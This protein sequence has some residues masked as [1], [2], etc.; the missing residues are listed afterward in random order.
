M[1]SPAPA[2]VAGAKPIPSAVK[3]ATA[4]LAKTDPL[5]TLAPQ[6]P[7]PTPEAVKHRAC[8]GGAAIE[9]GTTDRSAVAAAFGPKS[10]IVAWSPNDH[11]LAVRA[12]DRAGHPLGEAH[13]VDAPARLSSFGVRAVDGHYLVFLSETDYQGTSPVLALYAM[14]VDANGTPNPAVTKVAIGDRGMIDD[15]SPG[16]ARGVLVWAGPT[17]ATHVD[18]GRLIS[19]VVD[20]KG[21]LAQSFIEF[22]DP[23]PHD[24]A[25]AFYSLGKHT[26]VMIGPDVIV[27]GEVKPRKDDV[28]YQPDG[29][30]FAPT[31][32]AAT[33]PV[34]GFG[35]GK[36]AKTLRY[37]TLGLDGVLQF[38]KAEIPKSKPLR[39]PFA[40]HVSW[41]TITGSAGV[42][43]LMSI[44]LRDV[45]LATAKL[46]PDLAGGGAGLSSQV[47]WSGDQ[48]LVFVADGGKVRVAPIPCP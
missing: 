43:V 39:A 8:T 47:V 31:F 20:G 5:G 18:Q 27:D 2:P 26:V 25:R 15:I 23:A 24:R 28:S 6:P 37:G 45:D 48:L 13:V 32:D 36:D 44:D 38:D 3:P 16:A 29:F 11:Q 33:V 1:S 21:G 9:L 22:P 12:I 40:D 10:G 4:V 41:V 42:D 35:L 34:I 30:A 19:L 17:P 46:P 7:P 14:V